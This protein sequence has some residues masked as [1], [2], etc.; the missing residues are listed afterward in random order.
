MAA[1]DGAVAAE[2]TALGFMVDITSVFEV[3]GN[4]CWGDGRWEREGAGKQFAMQPVRQEYNCLTSR[5]E[6]SPTIKKL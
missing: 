1:L 5:T 3:E 2:A 4:G 6:I